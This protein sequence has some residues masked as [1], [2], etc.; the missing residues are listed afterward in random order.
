MSN[1]TDILEMLRN[2]KTI[3]VVGLSSKRIRPSHGVTAYMQQHGYRI[4]PVNPE[5]TEV[6]GEK[7]Y[8]SLRDVPEKIDIVNVFR[9]PEAVPS[10]VDDAIAIGAPYL[11]L[12]E[13]VVHAE[14]AQ[15]AREAGM[16]VVMDRCIFK[17]HR[18]LGL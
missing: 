11:W 16:K 8:A 1:D 18:R 14:A 9:R 13:D 5:E 2:G 7:A 12:Q 6:L 3:A 15:K 17:E 4:I 10:I